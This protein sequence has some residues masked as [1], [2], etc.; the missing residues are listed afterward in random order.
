[1]LL[2]RIHTPI[3]HRT[4]DDPHASIEIPEATCREL[5]FDAGRHWLRLDELNRFTW[6]GYD[7]RPIPGRTGD[8]AYG[9]LPPA[10]FARLRRGIL[11]LHQARQTR[12]QSRD[13]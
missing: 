4:P 1:L 7:L 11:A 2:S 13:G 12:V 6:P 10:P 3:T 8:F 9:M 5:G